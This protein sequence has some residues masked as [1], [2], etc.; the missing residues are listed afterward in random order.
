MTEPLPN[1]AEAP[2]NNLQYLRDLLDHDMN[3]VNDIVA[4]IK[5]QWKKDHLELQQAVDT[6]DVAE[7]RRLLHRIK[8]TFSPLGAGHLLYRQVADNGEA[9]LE[10]KGTLEGDHAYWKK[11]IG[12]MEQVVE[13]LSK[14][15]SR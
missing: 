3:A 9:F 14:E 8:S 2:Y 5:A 15:T 4:E 1:N 12:D 6:G 7:T 11:L 10:K 13:D